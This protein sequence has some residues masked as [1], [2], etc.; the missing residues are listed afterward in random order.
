[1]PPVDV[2]LK[3][4]VPLGAALQALEDLIPGLRFTVRDYGV[5]VTVGNRI[6]DG[7]VR[8]HDFWKHKPAEK[9]AEEK[10]AEPKK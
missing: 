3:T 5:L 6:P 2:S 8:V 7:G 9:K 1:M 10:P 4:E